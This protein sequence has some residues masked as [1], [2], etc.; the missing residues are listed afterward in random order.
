MKKIILIMLFSLTIF[1]NT[2]PCKLD[3][4]FG[5][6]V[7]N[8]GQAAQESMFE[9]KIFIQLN[10][11]TRFSIVEDGVTYDFKY[12]HNETYGTINDLLKHIGNSM[13]VDKLVK[14]IFHLQQKL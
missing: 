2:N 8:D 12:A 9:L 3:I 7:W 14:V 5:N 13:Q 11:P 10:Y 4:Y 6:G 1:A